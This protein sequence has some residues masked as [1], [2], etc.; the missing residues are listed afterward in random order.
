VT[1]SPGY[2]LD[3]VAVVAGYCCGSIVVI[4][5]FDIVNDVV[6]VVKGWMSE[7]SY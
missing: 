2:G 6:G 5:A 4:V 7:V 3:V 1:Y